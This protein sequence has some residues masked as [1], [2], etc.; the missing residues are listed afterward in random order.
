MYHHLYESNG[1]PLQ[2]VGVGLGALRQAVLFSSIALRR[3]MLVSLE[4]SNKDPAYEWFLAWMAQRSAA[5]S[6]AT[7]KPW[8]MSSWVRSHQLS[9]Q[10]A[11]EQRKNG[12][13]SVNFKL[14]AAPGTHWLKYRRAWIQVSS[15][16]SVSSCRC[17]TWHH[18]L[19]VHCGIS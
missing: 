12:S 5:A 18:Y 3:R 7:V 2:G 4:I 9:V 13:S 16:K 19:D 17:R 6:Q 1:N 15:S 10:T 8:S 11:Q 14:V